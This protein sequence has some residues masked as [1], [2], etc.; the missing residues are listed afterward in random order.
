MKDTI[1]KILSS[2]NFFQE[3]VI[4]S[5]S[6][7][8]YGSQ[9]QIDFHYIYDEGGSIKT[10]PKRIVSLGFNKV[11]EFELTNA[12]NE[13]QLENLDKLNWGANEV[14]TIQIEDLKNGFLAHI[15]WEGDRRID[16]VFGTLEVL[17]KD[18]IK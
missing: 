4:E 12:W 11:Q 6:F 1:A 8:N 17:K 15:L 9:V 16:I 5:I 18:S 7:N 3:C 14:S 13:S 10:E 2:Y